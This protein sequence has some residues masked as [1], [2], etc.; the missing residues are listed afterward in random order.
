ME[1]KRYY[2]IDVVNSFINENKQFKELN[3]KIFLKWVN[4][5]AIFK[6]KKM[7]KNRDHNGRYFILESEAK[8]KNDELFEQRDTAPF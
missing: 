7:I 6:G 8:S 5:L 1:N 2:N 3:T 4:E